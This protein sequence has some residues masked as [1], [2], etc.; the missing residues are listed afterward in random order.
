L[1]VKIINGSFLLGQEHKGGA[2]R[3]FPMLRALNARSRA[4]MNILAWLLIA[5]LVVATVI[6][7]GWSRHQPRPD[8]VLAEPSDDPLN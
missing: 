8:P 4:V 1:A 7:I 3:F 2:R 5:A 6:W